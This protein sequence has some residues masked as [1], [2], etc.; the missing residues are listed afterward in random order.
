MKAYIASAL[1]NAP[2]VRVRRDQ[3][4]KHGV[5]LTYDWT[6]HGSVQSQ[7]YEVM[8]QVA[9]A[10][11][12]GVRRANLVI[13]LLPGGRGTH[14]ELGIALA[15]KAKWRDMQII[16]C[17]PRA[18]ADGRECC[19][20]QLA[21]SGFDETD[22]CEIATWLR[23]CNRIPVCLCGAMNCTARSRLCRGFP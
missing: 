11:A 3:L 12:D 15:T 7:G 23:V 22:P 20:Y 18:G 19:F 17:G 14:A 4:A 5:E 2:A 1:E 21:D 13:V 10:E 6:A 9:R 16:V 8:A